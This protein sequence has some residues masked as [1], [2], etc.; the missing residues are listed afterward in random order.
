ME[1]E[2][3]KRNLSYSA[4]ILN[5][6]AVAIGMTTKEKGLKA[7]TIKNRRR[8]IL[9]PKQLQQLLPQRLVREYKVE[10]RVRK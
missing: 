8:R 5:A 6:A 2:V 9:Q 3:M 1:V 10:E 7:P 4:A